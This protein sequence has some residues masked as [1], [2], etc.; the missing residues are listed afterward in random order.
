MAQVVL[1]PCAKGIKWNEFRWRHL[2]RSDLGSAAKSKRESIT[3]ISIGGTN[4]AGDGAMAGKALGPTANPERE[5][6]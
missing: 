5:Q 4:L 2:V 6:G 1:R 3:S